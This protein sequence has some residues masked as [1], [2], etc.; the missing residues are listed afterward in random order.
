MADRMVEVGSGFWNVRGSFRLGGVVDIGTQSSLVR[1][2]DGHFVWLDAYAYDEAVARDVMSV[3]GGVERVSAIIHL[4]PFHT[5]HVREL[6]QRF[7]SAVLY[8]SDRHVRL[9]EDLPWAAPRVSDPAM[10]QRFADCLEFSVP[11][12]VD[13]ISRN[14]NVHFSSVLA[15]HPASSTIHVDDTLNYVVMPSPVRWLGIRDTLRWH[16]TLSAALERR[17][18]AADDFR[19]WALRLAERW[20]AAQNLCSAHAHALLGSQNEG[21][22]IR[23]RILDALDAVRS[24]LDTH[25]KRHG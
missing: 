25:R 8:G 11:R 16:P 9:A 13:F 3:I 6:H 14:E 17:P 18:G 7:P 1:R 12:G 22:P 23:R 2:P 15:W 4:H 21:P 20:G 24:V 19:D 5:L 10:H